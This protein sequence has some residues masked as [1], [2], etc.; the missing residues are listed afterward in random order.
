VSGYETFMK[1]FIN[2]LSKHSNNIALVINEKSYTYHQFFQKVYHLSIILK[3]KSLTHKIVVLLSE[4]TISL[5][6]AMLACLLSNVIYCPLNIENGIEKSKLILSK[7]KPDLIFCEKLPED[8]RDF[9]L[10]TYAHHQLFFY[11]DNDAHDATAVIDIQ[12]WF[13]AIDI[14]D[15]DIAYLFFTSG[16]TGMPKGVPISHHNLRSYLNSIT[17]L[18][19]FSLNDRFIQLSDIAFDL[20]IHEIIVS[21]MSGACLY[22]YH[23][24]KNL[25]LSKFLIEHRITQLIS[26]PSV[27]SFLV[28]QAQLYQIQFSH[29]R[30]VFLCGEPFS[31][32]LAIAFAARAKNCTLVNLYGP[33]EATVACTY[34]VFDKLKDQRVLVPIGKPFSSVSLTTTHCA[35]L[36]IAGDQVSSGYYLLDPKKK[37]ENSAFEFDSV[38]NTFRYYTGDCVS[39]DINGDYHFCSRLDDQWKIGGYRIEKNEIENVLRSLFQE[40]DIFVTP[41]YNDQQLIVSITGFSTKKISLKTQRAELHKRL[42]KSAIPDHFIQLDYIP[43]LSNGKVD[44]RKLKKFCFEQKGI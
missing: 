44:Y 43:K 20:S 1:T 39:R 5:Y 10:S 27:L 31:T 26:V 13:S 21:L 34:H 29:L 24:N 11:Q 38:H 3:Q 40:P 30:R 14:R 4:R 41:V 18:F 28:Q 33:T 22:I 12:Q 23:E 35:E 42:P 17:S 19:S 25:H 37:L 32:K 6:A 9:L 2:Q 8:L 7:L 15:H 16:S 36:V